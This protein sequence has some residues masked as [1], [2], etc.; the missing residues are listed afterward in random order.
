MAEVTV[1]K[2]EPPF[3]YRRILIVLEKDA[4]LR[5]V[6]IPF[7]EVFDILFRLYNFNRNECIKAIE[8]LEKAEAIEVWD[9]CGVVIENRI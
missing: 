8:D 5:G 7:A 4:I 3:L 9:F 1:N 6:Y 2:S